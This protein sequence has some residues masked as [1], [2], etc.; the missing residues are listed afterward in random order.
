MLGIFAALDQ[1]TRMDAE[2]IGQLPQ[3]GHVRLDL[4]ALGTGYG[5]AVQTRTLGQLLL[6]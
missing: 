3:R 6:S 4:I 2:S 5:G 1:F